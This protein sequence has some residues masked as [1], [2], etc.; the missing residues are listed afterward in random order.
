MFYVSISLT[1]S[2]GE[3]STLLIEVEW[4]LSTYNSEKVHR[5]RNSQQ[6]CF[7]MDRKV[8]WPVISKRGTHVQLS[9][10]GP[11][12]WSQMQMD[13]NLLLSC[14]LVSEINVMPRILS[15][16]LPGAIL[17]FP[18]VP[19]RWLPEETLSLQ[20]SLCLQGKAVG[21]QI[22]PPALPSPH[23]LLGEPSKVSIIH[24]SLQAQ[25]GCLEKQVLSQGFWQVL[26][27]FLLCD[28]ESH[29]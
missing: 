20:P 27:Y 12:T 16:P 25:T 11:E 17:T 15:Y 6:E 21:F 2:E 18:C 8:C 9:K 14:F 28:W 26:K 19:G 23:T 22:K 4:D 24:L 5:T 1:L 10:P 3:N 13:T 29:L 7:I